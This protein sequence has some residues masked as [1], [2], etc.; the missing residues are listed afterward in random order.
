MIFEAPPPEPYDPRHPT[1]P[2][3][4]ARKRVA[5]RIGIALG[6]DVVRPEQRYFLAWCWPDLLAAWGYRGVRV[7][8]Q[9]LRC[10]GLDVRPPGQRDVARRKALRSLDAHHHPRIEV[11]LAR[12]EHGL[13]IEQQDLD[14]RPRKLAGWRRNRDIAHPGRGR[15]VRRLVGGHRRRGPGKR[16]PGHQDYSHV[17]PHLIAARR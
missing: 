5:D 4:E 3:D 12:P 17:P 2:L 11:L 10:E 14:R 15:S 13:L 9:D 8:P 1:D 7:L 6:P 16:Q